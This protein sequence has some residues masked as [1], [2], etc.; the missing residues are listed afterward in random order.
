MMVCAVEPPFYARLI[1][2]LGL[3]GEALPAQYD[4]SGW[5]QLHARFAAVFRTR[6]R[7]AWTALLEPL[8]ACVSPVLNL[9]EAPQH[10]HLQARGTF[11][12]DA[13]GHP[14]PA[15]A[16]PV[17]PA[18]PAGAVTDLLKRWGVAPSVCAGLASAA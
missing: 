2:G 11:V 4:R 1:E 6:S 12:P 8:G 9:A 16:P 14:V 7:D 10:P 5:P 15:A 17:P 3:A 13:L 18:W